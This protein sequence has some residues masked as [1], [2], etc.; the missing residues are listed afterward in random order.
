M[1]VLIWKPS[2]DQTEYTAHWNGLVVKL[3]FQPR[4]D[5]KDPWFAYV[6]GKRVAVKGRTG[7]WASLRAAKEAVELTMQRVLRRRMAELAAPHA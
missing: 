6:N 7:R 2:P 1:S 3:A 5:G 4:A